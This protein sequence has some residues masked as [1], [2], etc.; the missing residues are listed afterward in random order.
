MAPATGNHRFLS[1]GGVGKQDS[2]AGGEKGSGEYAHGVLSG[3]E[4]LLGEPALEWG[5]PVDQSQ[6]AVSKF[7]RH[8]LFV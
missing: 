4:R 8:R 7:P 5:E 1:H 3:V 2:K 6:A